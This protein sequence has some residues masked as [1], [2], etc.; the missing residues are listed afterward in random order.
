[1]YISQ[2]KMTFLTANY[3]VSPKNINQFIEAM[4]HVISD[5][6]Y[7]ILEAFQGVGEESD[8]YANEE[9]I[10]IETAVDAD[11]LAHYIEDYDDWCRDFSYKME[12][13]H[14]I[15]EVPMPQFLVD[16]LKRNNKTSWMLSK[17]ESKCA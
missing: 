11:R 6:Y 7:D 12:L 2:E 5:C 3:G 10:L 14:D 13:A 15:K 8:F 17:K 4:E 1:M 16:Y 9:A